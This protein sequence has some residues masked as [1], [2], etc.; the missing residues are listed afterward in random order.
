MLTPIDLIRAIVDGMAG[1]GFGRIVNITSAAVKAP[2]AELGLSNGARAGLTGFVGGRGAGQVAATGV[3][4]N[5]LLPGRFATDRL[6]ANFAAA[7]AATR[8]LPS[9][10]VER[11]ALARRARAGAVRRSGRVRPALRLSVLAPRR[12][13]HRRR[14][15]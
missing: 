12:L 1:R 8:S 4:V 9:S 6:T 13:H 5:N 11:A 14:I 15:C 7:A 3:T 10:E 2:I